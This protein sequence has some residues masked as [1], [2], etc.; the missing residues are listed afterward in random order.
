MTKDE[1]TQIATELRRA[2]KEAED[3]P[4]GFDYQHGWLKSSIRNI[5]EK[6]E[7]GRF[8]KKGGYS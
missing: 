1:R 8:P 7:E 2:L 6:I 5:A 4:E 3:Q